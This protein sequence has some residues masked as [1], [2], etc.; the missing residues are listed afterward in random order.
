MGI[1]LRKRVRFCVNGTALLGGRL[2]SGVFSMI[3]SGRMFSLFA[4]IP[5]PLRSKSHTSAA[6]PQ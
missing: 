3:T 4:T 6:G 2:G 5:N 1:V